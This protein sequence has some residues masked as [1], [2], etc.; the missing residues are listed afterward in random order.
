MIERL[1]VKQSWMHILV[2]LSPGQFFLPIGLS[3][4][5]IKWESFG[6]FTLSRE[7]FASLLYLESEPITILQRTNP[8][9]TTR[10]ERKRKKWN[11]QLQVSNEIRRKSKGSLSP[12]SILKKEWK[13][14][15]PGFCH[16]HSTFNASFSPIIC[17]LSGS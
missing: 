3:V 4:H 11:D 1:K 16:W 6:L 2:I 14:L 13:G 10:A 12:R 5:C 7:N 15:I 9:G 17:S 8:R